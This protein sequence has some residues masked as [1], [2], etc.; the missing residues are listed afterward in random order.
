MPSLISM[1]AAPVT[2]APAES[3][4]HR[5]GISFWIILWTLALGTRVLAGFYLPNA[6]QDGYSDAEM[7]ARL[8][9]A[10][11][12]GQFGVADLYGFWL[13]FFQLVAAIPNIWLGDPLLCG[14]ILSSFCGALSCML[15][16]AISYR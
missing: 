8:S 5:M 10:L 13:P 14:K 12:S 16:F 11:A 6:E 9:A 7:I 1:R 3:N 4:G 15:V 2:K